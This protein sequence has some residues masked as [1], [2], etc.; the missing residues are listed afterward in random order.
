MTS[1]GVVSPSRVAGRAIV[2]AEVASTRLPKEILRE[3]DREAARRGI[4]RSVYLTDLIER[5][6]LSEPSSDAAGAAE[7]GLES[8]LVNSSESLRYRNL[9]LGEVHDGGLPLPPA[10]LVVRE[11]VGKPGGLCASVQ[12]SPLP[13]ASGDVRHGY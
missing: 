4:S 11:T 5:G 2:S 9:G 6:A 8:S 7:L 3:I 1:P 12:L 10:G 13:E